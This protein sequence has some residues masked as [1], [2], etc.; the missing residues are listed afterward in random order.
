[1]TTFK[2]NIP[3]D[4]VLKFK[5]YLHKIGAEFEEDFEVSD[6]YKNLMD[7]LMIQHKDGKLEYLSEEEFRR[8][9]LLK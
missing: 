4:E 1:M 3:E 8:Q 2:V 9:S 6:E 7:E 5:E